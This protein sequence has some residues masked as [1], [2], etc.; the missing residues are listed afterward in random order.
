MKLMVVAIGRGSSVLGNDD[1]FLLSFTQS[2]LL[3]LLFFDLLVH[4][5]DQRTPCVRL[6]QLLV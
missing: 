6:L 5:L 1:R 4:H 2:S 3:L